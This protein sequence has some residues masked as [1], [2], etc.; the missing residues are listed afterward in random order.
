MKYILLSL[1][2][3]LKLVAI[4]DVS[5]KCYDK[6]YIQKD[7]KRLAKSGEIQNHTKVKLNGLG[8]IIFFYPCGAPSILKVKETTEFNVEHQCKNNSIAKS[9]VVIF[10]DKWFAKDEKIVISASSR[11]VSQV[12]RGDNYFV[13][14]KN[15]VKSIDLPIYDEDAEY[16]LN[17]NDKDYEVKS[18]ISSELISIPT[19][20][21]QDNSKNII[22][23]YE[24]DV[25]VFNFSVEYIDKKSLQQKYSSSELSTLERALSYE[26]DSNST[27][28]TNGDISYLLQ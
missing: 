28:Y 9:L 19:S 13:V 3:S 2:L 1:V 10:F 22:K 6:S 4:E 11:S 17:I 24:D 7:E 25:K 20:L 16:I 18:F 23:I 5:Y 14:G 26:K 15:N 8:K 12:S 27:L 21:L